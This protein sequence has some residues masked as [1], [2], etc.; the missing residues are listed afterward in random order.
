MTVYGITNLTPLDAD[1]VLLARWVRRPTARFGSAL[2]GGS[3]AVLMT[4]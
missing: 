4:W 3:A 1:P 2:L